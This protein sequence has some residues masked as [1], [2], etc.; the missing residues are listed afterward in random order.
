MKSLTW[1]IL[2]G[3]LIAISF[4]GYFIPFSWVIGFFI[5]FKLIENES[6]KKSLVFS[7]LS[8]FVFSLLTLYWTVYA[9][10]YYGGVSIFLGIPLL[11]ILASVFS[12]Y[13]FVIPAFLLKKAQSR[14]KNLAFILFP[15]LWTLIEISR[16]FFPFGG[17]PW[18]L[19]GYSLSYINSV[20]QIVSYFSIYFLS[21]LAVFIPSILFFL[22]K[23][24]KIWFLSGILGVF[25]FILVLHF[26]GVYRINSFEMKGIKKKVAVIQ[27][28]ISQD[29]KLSN[30]D[31]VAVIDRYISLIKSASLEKP[32]LII[33]PE[34]ALPFLYI[35]GD[36]NLKAYF[37]RQIEDIKIPLLLGADTAFFENRNIYIYNSIIFLDKDKEIVDIYHKI[38]LVPFGEYVPFPF[39]IFSKLF[40]YLEGYDFSSGKEK[41]IISYKEWK[42]VPLI[43]FEAIFPNFVADFSRNGNILVNISNDAWFGKT[44][45]PFQH[46]E[47]A[48]VRAIETGKFLIRGTNTGISAIIDPT[49]IIKAKLGLFRE[50]Y[51]TE[52]I[53][54][55]E[56]T[57]FWV[58]NHRNIAIVFLV[59][60]ISTMI[61]LEW[62]R[63]R[64]DETG[65]KRR[66]K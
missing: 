6:L 34:S 5:L 23:K 42:I 9:I 53:F 3:V 44:V 46:F 15:F 29:V 25:S 12:V 32:D 65:N 17:F 52:N 22:Y 16:E 40:P 49:G 27:G 57:T 7:F 55:L 50:G 8:G 11:V 38:K 43:C 56:N 13:Q 62:K 19:L 54:L 39:R 1:V 10:T 21:F 47:M 24:E 48:R 30:A 2:S 66:N 58:K 35:N 26:W 63:E 14:Y 37:L 4:P 18:N 41:K 45:A 28:N 51:I 60:F 31:P 36:D 33:L 64:K 20:A 59:L 61:Y